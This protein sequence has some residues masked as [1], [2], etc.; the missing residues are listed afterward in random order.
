[1]KV[2]QVHHESL[3]SII[4]TALMLVV[5]KGSFSAIESVAFINA[6]PVRY[7]QSL[8]V[9]RHSLMAGFRIFIIALQEDYGNIVTFFSKRYFVEKEMGRCIEVWKESIQKPSCIFSKDVL[10]TKK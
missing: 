4:I 3:K 10:L 8:I 9:Y 7:E 6:Q 5:R 1:M 2:F